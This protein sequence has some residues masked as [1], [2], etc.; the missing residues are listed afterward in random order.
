[1]S[2]S[3][4]LRFPLLP[5]LVLGP[6]AFAGPFLTYATGDTPV[7]GGDAQV[8][9]RVIA[10]PAVPSSATVSVVL[11]D[12]TLRLDGIDLLP[13]L[14]SAVTVGAQGMLGGGAITSYNIKTGTILPALV[15]A[16]GAGTRPSTVLNTPA[17]T[18]YVE[19]QFGFG[20]AAVH[21]IMRTPV[22]GPPGTMEVV[23][24]GGGLENLEGLEIVGSRLFF[25]ARD[26]GDG[27][28]RALY[29]I[30]LNGAGL[31]NGVAAT[32]LLGGLT[33]AAAGDGSDELVYDPL[34]DRLYGTNIINGEII[35]WD[36]SAGVGGFLIS[37]ADIATG[38]GSLTRLGTA[39][40]DGIRST[41]TG[42]LVM[43]GLA[44]VIASVSLAGIELD[45]LDAGDVRI[46]Y[47][48]DLLGTG[49]RFDDLTDLT[50]IPEPS[51]LG[52]VAFGLAWLAI[53]GQ[54]R[55]RLRLRV[56]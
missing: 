18:Y 32:E 39:Q 19:N 10:D 23:F 52:L 38:G 3:L 40:L 9:F 5:I 42:Y 6:V 8:I 27:S 37:G 48:S 4:A 36:L 31:W 13:G 29:S 12:T 35:Y 56:R 28:K 54:K 20:G 33:A 16:T 24:P 43:T 22:A 50:P 15:P 25:F 26:A 49:N 47:D 45:G 7:P 21:R 1:M 14:P 41:N 30:G 2:I 55:R 44:G 46:L 11:T 17:H 53:S 51:T 34:S